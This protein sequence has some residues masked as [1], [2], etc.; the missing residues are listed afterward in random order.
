RATYGVSETANEY[1]ERYAAHC[2]KNLPPATHILHHALQ[3]TVGE[4]AQQQGSKV[5]ADWLRFD[6][7]N[8][9]SLSDDEIESIE[10]IVAEKVQLGA[11][12]SWNTVP[13][14]EAREAGAMML[15]GEKYPDPVRMVSMGEFSKELCGGT[16]VTNTNQIDQFELVVEE[17]VSSGT[18]R[19][20]ALTGERAKQ[21]RE[22]VQQLLSQAAKALGTDPGLVAAKAH[23]LSLSIRGL[24]K[25]LAGSGPAKEPE[26]GK[27]LPT[28]TYTQQR[29]VLRDAARSLNV[30]QTELLPRIESL[31]NEKAKLEKQIAE[32]ASSGEISVETL[33]DGAKEVNGT[34]VVVAK[35]PGATPNLMRQWIDQIRQKN[36]SP[37]AV[38]FAATSGDSKV[39]LVAGISRDLVDKGLSAGTW[40]SKVAPIVGGGGGGKPDLAQ[41]G[42]KD[43]S[44]ID[45]AIQTAVSTISEMIG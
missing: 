25:Q 45:D 31:L 37:T 10:S 26:A 19:V 32:L 14:A 11:D 13:L 27:S 5:D 35:T 42:G 8:Q 6:F 12:V 39:L 23:G 43:P 20:V 29:L 44:K 15:F 18:R 28:D 34:V 36:D 40:I 30:A 3:S 1:Y 22:E 41:A 4:H 2:R 33:L 9:K 7:T 17:S 16:H 21:H 38:L 24:K